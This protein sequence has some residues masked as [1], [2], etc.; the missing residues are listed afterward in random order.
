[1]DLATSALYLTGIY[2]ASKA[3]NAVL[4][5]VSSWRNAKL[6]IANAKKDKQETQ[7]MIDRIKQEK[8]NPALRLRRP[9]WG[10]QQTQSNA[11][12]TS[13]PPPSR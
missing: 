7:E 8:E 2:F 12:P 6:E 10:W 9:V 3:V 1:M 5:I 13:L 4:D 11:P